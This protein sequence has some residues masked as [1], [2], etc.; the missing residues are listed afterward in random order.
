[1]MN[2]F[3][4]L[5]L[6]LLTLSSASASDMKNNNAD[7]LHHP[8]GSNS[9]VNHGETI[10]KTSGPLFG[11]LDTTKYILFYH[12]DKQSQTT[13]PG[14]CKAFYVLFKEHVDEIFPIKFDKLPVES[15]KLAEEIYGSQAKCTKHIHLPALKFIN[16]V[17]HK[18]EDC[19]QAYENLPQGLSP[20]FVATFMANAEDFNFFAVLP[21]SFTDF[22]QNLSNLPPDKLNALWVNGA[23]IFQNIWPVVIQPC[24]AQLSTFSVEQLKSLGQNYQISENMKHLESHHE[25]CLVALQKFTTEQ[26]DALGR[27]P[28]I[29]KDTERHDLSQCLSAL[30]KLSDKQIDALGRNFSIFQDI[31]NGYLAACFSALKAFPVE[32]IDALGKMNPPIFKGL[33][34]YRLPGYLNAL[35]PVPDDKR[36][37]LLANPWILEKIKED[38]CYA[39]CFNSLQNFSVDTLEALGRNPLIFQDIHGGNHEESF[40]SLSACS[41]EQIDALGRNAIILQG[42]KGETGQVSYTLMKC[43]PTLLTYPIKKLDILSSN[44]SSILKD[45]R[46]YQFEDNIKALATFSVDQL[47]AL[48]FKTKFLAKIKSDDNLSSSRCLAVLQPFSGEQIDFIADHMDDLIFNIVIRSLD[49]REALGCTKALATLSID[50]LKALATQAKL[51]KV[52]MSESYPQKFL[53]ALKAF[54][55]EQ[56]AIIAEHT[57][58]LTPDIFKSSGSA[59]NRAM[60]TLQNLQSKRSSS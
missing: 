34:S 13:I 32:Q 29:V 48:S 21:Y 58:E 49:S 28:S 9:I 42:I 18:P 26:F 60:E 55:P 33:E 59:K 36:K 22:V 16:C 54:T 57:D 24:L 25:N 31:D 6:T 14:V 41:V 39:D 20:S 51:I 5:A 15:K 53:Q 10:D 52:I 50:Q 46:D 7:E 45:I 37:V 47:K 30:S 1:M 3:V 23:S 38:A 56:I 19:K 44:N 4:I 8:K 17:Y 35:V 11:C 43:L 40:K 2:N 27:H 12:L